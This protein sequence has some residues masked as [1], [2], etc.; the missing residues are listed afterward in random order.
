[1]SSEENK[2]SDV[3]M[4]TMT[5]GDKG[6]VTIPKPIRDQ[7][8]LEKGDQLFVRFEDDSPVLTLTAVDPK[9]AFDAVS[10]KALE[11][12]REGNSEVVVENDQKTATA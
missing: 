3:H 6:R 2:D 9:K 7:L 5:I 10:K 4:E 12:H 1:M 8:D 11:E